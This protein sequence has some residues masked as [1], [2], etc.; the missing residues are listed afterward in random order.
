MPSL[1]EAMD[2]LFDRSFVTPSEWLT[3]ARIDTP[4]IDVVSK[5]EAIVVKVAL[6][7]VKPEEIET[8]ITGNTLE[9][10]GAYREEE[11]KEEEGYLFREL[12][13]GEF[14]RTVLL[15][16]GIKSDAAEATFKEGILTLVIPKVEPVKPTAIKVKAG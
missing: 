7:G 11:K 2:R 9:I 8:T 10:H 13:R 4:A 12:N 15:P 3:L 6:P 16:A 1:R 5:P 14:R